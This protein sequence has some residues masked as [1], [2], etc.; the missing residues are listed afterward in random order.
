MFSTF[1]L[2]VTQLNILKE[3]G[4]LNINNNYVHSLIRRILSRVGKF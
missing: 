4:H 3:N 2:D 1:S